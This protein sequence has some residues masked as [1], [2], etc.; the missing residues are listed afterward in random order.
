M[1]RI[2]DAN[3]IVH[4]SSHLRHAAS[5]FH[6]LNDRRIRETN[7][8]RPYVPSVPRAMT[9]AV[10]V[11]FVTGHPA[12]SREIENAREA[13]FDLVADETTMDRA[14][15]R[16]R[17]SL[18]VAAGVACVFL[19]AIGILIPVLPTTPFLL[20]AAACFL[21]SS[22]RLH[23]WLLGN[24]VFGEYLRRYVN[25]EGIPLSSKIGTLA[26]LWFTLAVS[27]FAFVPAGLWW[28]RLVLAAIGVGV[29]LRI[30]T[31]PTRIS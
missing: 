24:R 23:G 26:F 3:V 14:P 31:I 20:L 19:G 10:G 25:G 8:G 12:E 17:R 27:I 1:N 18:L 6:S 2:G 28:V 21:R 5:S 9:D 11:E 16:L 22:E 30:A 29:T 7:A 13:T 4:T 15:G